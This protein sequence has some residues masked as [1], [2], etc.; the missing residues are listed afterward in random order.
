VVSRLDPQPLEATKRCD[1]VRWH[2]ASRFQ[3]H[4]PGQ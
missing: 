2:R 3:T 4:S 1:R